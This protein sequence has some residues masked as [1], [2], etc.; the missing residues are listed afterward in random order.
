MSD[1]NF[2]TEG[3]RRSSLWSEASGS[4]RS[5]IESRRSSVAPSF[6]DTESTSRR[7]SLADSSSRRSSLFSSRRGSAEA[8]GESGQEKKKK[9][10][11]LFGG[12]K[13]KSSA[14]TDSKTDDAPASDR[15]PRDTSKCDG[16]E[17]D[18]WLLPS[19][20]NHIK[21]LEIISCPAPKGEICT[22]DW[23][24]NTHTTGLGHSEKFVHSDIVSLD[25]YENLLNFA[26]IL[27]LS[28]IRCQLRLQSRRYTGQYYRSQHTLITLPI[29]EGRE[30]SV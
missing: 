6:I 11:S 5:S 21:P 20:A 26:D 3:S 30:R 16:I 17:L 19:C 12:F 1:W 8:H 22:V 10:G 2:P 14:S 28:W 23:T 25:T 24:K 18:D 9:K 13:R 4:R 29:D 27:V 15:L 7:S